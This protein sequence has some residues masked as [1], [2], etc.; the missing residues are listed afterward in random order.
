MWGCE[1]FIIPLS[2]LDNNGKSIVIPNDSD[3]PANKERIKAIYNF[4]PKYFLYKLA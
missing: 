3:K 2:I 4:I 1:W